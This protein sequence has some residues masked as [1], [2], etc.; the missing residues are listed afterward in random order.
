VLVLSH[1]LPDLYKRLG[2][3]CQPT[4][5]K[6]GET[7]EIKL[8]CLNKRAEEIIQGPECQLF[9]YVLL[10]IKLIDDGDLKNVSTLQKVNGFK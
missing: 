1:Y 4:P 3:P 6:A 9:I 8:H 7:A 10:L 2:L 5:L